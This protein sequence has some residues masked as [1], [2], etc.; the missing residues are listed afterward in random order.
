MKDER[1]YLRHI[2]RCISR[3]EE[4]TAGGRE[5]FFASPLVQDGVIRNLQTMAESSQ[6]LSAQ[7]RGSRRDVDWK[8]LAGFRNSGDGHLIGV[9]GHQAAE[10]SCT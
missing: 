4:Y 2:L 8:A 7:V 9:M 6:R 3:I 10:G 1:V 5:S